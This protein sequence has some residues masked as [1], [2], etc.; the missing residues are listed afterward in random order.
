[1]LLRQPFKRLRVLPQLGVL[2]EHHADFI[3][4]KQIRGNARDF[5]NGL[6]K[7]EPF[8]RERPRAMG[9]QRVADC[10]KTDQA[11]VRA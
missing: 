3:C 2:Q 6:R 10:V 9:E 4:L 1:L 5:I 7:R 8:S 11:P